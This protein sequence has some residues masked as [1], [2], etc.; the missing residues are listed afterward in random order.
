MVSAT[1]TAA[2]SYSKSASTAT[3]QVQTDENGDV[4]EANLNYW[5]LFKF[6]QYGDEL[7]ARLSRGRSA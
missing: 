1:T 2:T 6:D 7:S 4:W 3:N 5:D